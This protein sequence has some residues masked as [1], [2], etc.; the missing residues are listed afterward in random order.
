V[1]L[2]AAA[3]A[4]PGRCTRVALGFAALR[5]LLLTAVIASP[6]APARDAPRIREPGADA[7]S[8]VRRAARPLRAPTRAPAPA[9]GGPPDAPAIPP[10]AL[11]RQGRAGGADRAPLGGAHRAGCPP[12]ASS[13]RRDALQADRPQPSVRDPDPLAAAI[14][15]GWLLPRRPSRSAG[16]KRGA[17]RPAS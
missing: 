12:Y 17:A 4:A 2:L 6:G 10:A 7:A 1:E 8:P 5:E 3:A 13:Q 11:P 15:L 9:A 16:R 14:G